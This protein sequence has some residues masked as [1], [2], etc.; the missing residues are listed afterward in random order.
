MSIEVVCC[1][2][3][4]DPVARHHLVSLARHESISKVWVVRHDKIG[5][6]DIPKVE[7][8]LIPTCFKLFRFLKMISA[9]I[10]IGRRKEVKAF[11][12]FNPIPY[13][14]FGWIGARINKKA[15]H[16]GFIGLDWNHYIK[17]SWGRIFLPILRRGDFITVPG[18]SMRRE[19]LEGGFDAEKV[20]VMPHSTDIERFPVAEND[21]KKYCC[22]Y[23]GELSKL[24]QVDVIIR[25]FAKVLQCYPQE[26]L[27]IVG[28][29]P[30]RKRLEMLA[31]KL[32]VTESV[33]FAGHVE[34]VQSYLAAAKILVIASKSEGFPSAMVEGMCCG[35]VPVSTPVGAIPDI[36]TDGENGLLFVNGDIDALAE[37][38]KRLLDN[39]EFFDRLQKKIFQQRLI[40][41]HN[42]VTSLWDNW[43]NKL[44]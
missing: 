43:F 7:Y 40:F 44:T 18:G 42:A 22:I 8:I 3:L 15:I 10:R 24:K 28:D 12:S 14:L 25:A 34:N 21:S 4:K 2:R 1:V 9:C 6:S 5:P 39:Q 35:L 36:I 32:G 37:C 11:V 30:E 17:K 41:S 31:K 20:M 27:C 23:V 26:R 19:M 16:F 33:E 13:G 29:G 38:V